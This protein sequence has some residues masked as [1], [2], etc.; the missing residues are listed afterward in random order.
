MK[1]QDTC[2]YGGG[3]AIW[4]T[5]KQSEYIKILHMSGKYGLEDSF[6]IEGMKAGMFSFKEMIDRFSTV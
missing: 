1:K 6:N 3:A 2:V 5:G 4:L